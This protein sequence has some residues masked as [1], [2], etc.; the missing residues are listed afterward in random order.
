MPTQYPTLDTNTKTKTKTIPS[1]A[2]NKDY[3]LKRL[4]SE[5][6]KHGLDFNRYMLK[7]S[8]VSTATYGEL[9]APGQIP[10]GAV[11]KGK[12]PSQLRKYWS[13]TAK[14]PHSI[15]QAF[16]CVNEVFVEEKAYL[17]PSGAGYLIMVIQSRETQLRIVMP[18]GAK[19]QEK[20]FREIAKS[21]GKYVV[22]LLPFDAGAHLGLT[23]L[24]QLT[25]VNTAALLGY[26]NRGRVPTTEEAHEVLLNMVQAF[27]EPNS[28]PSGFQGVEVGLVHT[29]LIL[30]S[31]E[32]TD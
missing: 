21:R 27:A 14:V 28:I 31:V 8:P 18:M 1:S 9:M 22:T 13:V 4:A 19:K 20:F 5:I 16:S 2:W 29:I 7:N 3:A 23:L 11:C 17:C 32:K 30:P 24:V 10:N 26:V 6:E 25:P 15:W 12:V